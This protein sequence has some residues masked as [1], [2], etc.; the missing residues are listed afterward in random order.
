MISSGDV[1]YIDTG[2]MYYQ[3]SYMIQQAMARTLV[4]W[5]PAETKE[6][7]PDLAESYEVAEDGKSVTF[8]IKDGIEFSPPVTAR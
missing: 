5:P 8:T 6:P 2:A 7:Q 3:F 1:D 4:G